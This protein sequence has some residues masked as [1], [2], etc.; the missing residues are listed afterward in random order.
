MS[1]TL[2]R[3]TICSVKSLFLNQYYSVELLNLNNRSNTVLNFRGFIRTFIFQK[4]KSIY[5]WQYLIQLQRIEKLEIQKYLFQIFIYNHVKYFTQ[6]WTEMC[7]CRLRATDQLVQFKILSNC[8]SDLRIF[9]GK[10]YTS[11]I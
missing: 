10:K 5:Q 9:N 1:R 6:D 2:T 7:V 8:N 4:L 11:S 3:L